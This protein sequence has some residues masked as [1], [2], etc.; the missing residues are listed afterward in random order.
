M[1]RF[2]EDI[3]SR[4]SE[5]RGILI[6]VS[7]GVRDEDGKYV[8]ETRED[9]R[10]DVF[11]NR[12]I[13]GTGKVLEEIVRQEIG[14]KVRSIELNLMQRCASQAASSTDLLES[15]LLGAMAV[16]C[17][18]QGKNGHM[19]VVKRVKNHPYRVAYTSVPVSLVANKEKTV[20]LEWINEQGNDIEQPLMDYL[21]PLIAGE[22]PFSLSNGIPLYFKIGQW[23]EA[24][25]PE[26]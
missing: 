13:A 15:R 17:I 21:Q 16:Q 12:D 3:R 19:A 10:T 7:E 23:N 18:L 26:Y 6:A 1:E 2:L 22:V 9:S 5:K 24:F 11:G 20:P 8:T 4:Q 25:L 14:C